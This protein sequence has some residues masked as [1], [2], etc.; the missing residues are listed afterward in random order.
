[1]SDNSKKSKKEA[2][3]SLLDIPRKVQEQFHKAVSQVSNKAKESWDSF[4]TSLE[5]SDNERLVWFSKNILRCIT[6]EAPVI[7]GYCVICVVVHLLSSTILPGFSL[8]LGFDDFFT[9]SNPIHYFRVFSQLFAHSSMS[10]LKGN[11]TYLLLVGP[12]TEAHYGSK[13]IIN[14]MRAVAISSAVS[15]LV[16]GR[17]NSRQ[18]GAS[19]VVFALIIMSSLICAKMDKIPLS[20]ILIGILYLGEE[21][22]KLF[23]GM[24]EISHHAHL[25]GGVVGAIIGF[26]M[27]GEDVDNVSRQPPSLWPTA[28]AKDKK[29]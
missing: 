10:H 28:S 13:A 27:N 16:L 18:L 4:C 7:C 20:F 25:V 5:A 6:I 1:M 21:L 26:R 29:T 23:F 3:S 22:V 24:D 9:V 12:P 15:H 19:G 14:V 11:M 17:R 2:T 8:F